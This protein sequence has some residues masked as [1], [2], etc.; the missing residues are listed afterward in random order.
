MNSLSTILFYI[1]LKQMELRKYGM[2]SLST[3]LFYIILKQNVI[4]DLACE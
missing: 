2:V 3:I 1:I 4:G